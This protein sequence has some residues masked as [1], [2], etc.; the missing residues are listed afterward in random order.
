MKFTRFERFDPITL[1][2][3]KIA[4]FERKQAK[5]AAKYPL[6]SDEIK[7]RQRSLEEEEQRRNKASDSTEQN[8][9]AFHA[10]VWKKARKSYFEANPD[11][12]AAIRKMWSS[13]TGPLTCT[14]YIYVVDFCTGVLAYRQAASEQ[15]DREVRRRICAEGVQERLELECA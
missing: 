8:Y 5:E 4:A 12:Q 10:R 13:W 9:R 1:T 14:Y 15:R 2:L 7:A 6:F 11:Q 3:R